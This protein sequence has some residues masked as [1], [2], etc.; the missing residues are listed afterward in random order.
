MVKKIYIKILRKLGSLMGIQSLIRDSRQ[1]KSPLACKSSLGFWYTGNLFNT[2]DI[3]YGIFRNG[4]VEKEET[5][6]V[7]RLL[8]QLPK[9]FTFYDIGANTGYYGIMTGHLFTESKVYSF[10]PVEKHLEWLRENVE[11]NNLATRL[12][13]LPFA[14]G[15]KDSMQDIYLSGSGSTLDPKF[16]DTSGKEKVTIEV[17]S[18]DGLVKNNDLEKANF[19]KIDV[20]GYEY[21]ALKGMENLLKDSK[22]ILFVEIAKTFISSG[23]TFNHPDFLNIFKLVSE[24]GYDS[25]I[26]TGDKLLSFNTSDSIPD[27]VHM[28]LFTHKEFHKNIKLIENEQK[29]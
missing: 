27:G 26:L 16:I 6:L 15:E 14:V 7:L 4:I 24:L 10:E 19:I 1:N 11:I 18:I 12:K 29:D 25:H 3:S 2:S 9:N 5:D 22:P 23:S 20:E 21:P 28:Y 8:K 17:K 13:V